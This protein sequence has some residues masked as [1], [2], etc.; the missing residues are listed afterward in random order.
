MSYWGCFYY[1]HILSQGCF[2]SLILFV[3]FM[4]RILG[5]SS[6]VESVLLFFFFLLLQTKEFKC[7]GV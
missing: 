6:C 3:I 7:L 5:C 2:L 4:D 1:V